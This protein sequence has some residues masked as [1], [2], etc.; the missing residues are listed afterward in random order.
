MMLMVLFFCTQTHF[1]TFNTS[2]VG[3]STTRPYT[4][5]VINRPVDPFKVLLLVAG[6]TVFFIA[7]NLSQS[8]MFFYTSGT[9][10]GGLAAALIVLFVL[11][12]FL[13]KVCRD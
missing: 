11:S 7:P 3:I 4:A 1:P 8:T 9:L 6:I 10:F 13:P 2:C 5:M 12:K